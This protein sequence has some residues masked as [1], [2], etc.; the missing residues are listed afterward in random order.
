MNGQRFIY[1]RVLVKIRGKEI[2]EGKIVDAKEQQLV[3]MRKHNS[4]MF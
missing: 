3:G 1:K 2:E 4:S